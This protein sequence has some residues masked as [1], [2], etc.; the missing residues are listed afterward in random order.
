MGGENPDDQGTTLTMTVAPPT[1]SL[2]VA[3]TVTKVVGSVVTET[4]TNVVT[5]T[6]ISISTVD[7]SAACVCTTVA[8]DDAEPPRKYHGL[9]PYVAKVV[10]PGD[11]DAN[12]KYKFRRSAL[13]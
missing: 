8:A 10:D 6:M 12:D 1:S 5:A 9:R 3:S 7:T 13:Y 11:H 2:P 4:I